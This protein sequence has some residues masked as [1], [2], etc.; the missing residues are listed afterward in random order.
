MKCENCKQEHDGSFATGRFCSVKCARSFSAKV[1]R[2]EINKRVSETMK[3]RVSDGLWRRPAGGGF[4]K[5]YDPRRR[6]F[7]EEDNEKAKI[8]FKKMQEEY[9]KNTPFNLLTKSIRKRILIEE[10]GHNCEKCKNNQWMDSPIPL[11]LDHIDGNNKNNIKENLKL[12]C[13][14]CHALT[15][16]WRGKN[17]KTKRKIDEKV[18]VETLKNSKNISEALTKLNLTPCGGNYDRAKRL[19]FREEMVLEGGFEPPKPSF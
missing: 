1:N 14:N 4:K 19:L 5:G 17:C 3:K 6:K 15:P 8:A 10:R 18:F 2:E 7:S 16:T 13:P 11:E 12:L 9:V